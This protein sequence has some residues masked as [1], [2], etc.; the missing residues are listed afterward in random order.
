MNQLIQAGA[1][2]QETQRETELKATLAS[3]KRTFPGKNSNHR[4][5]K[6]SARFADSY[7]EDFR[8]Q[9]SSSRSVSSIAEEVRN[10]CDDNSWTKY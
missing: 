10:S 6:A 1:D 8:S 7:V 3:L 2:R 5:L 9:R 4:L